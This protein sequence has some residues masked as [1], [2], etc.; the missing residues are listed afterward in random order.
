MTGELFHGGQEAEE[1]TMSVCS[2]S[3]LSLGS[4]HMG[5]RYPQPERIFSAKSSGHTLR[6]TP[7]GVPQFHRNYNKPCQLDSEDQPSRKM[8]KP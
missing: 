6:D 7:G 8:K 5:W 1:R 2:D 3:L 4:Q